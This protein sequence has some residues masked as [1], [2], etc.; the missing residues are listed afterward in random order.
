MRDTPKENKQNLWISLLNEVQ[1]NRRNAYG[2]VES[3][4]KPQLIILGSE[5]TGKTRLVGCISKDKDM[6][7]GIGLDYH[8]LNL[9]EDGRED[10]LN[11]G[12]WCL[13]GDP[14]LSNLLKFALNES[15][16]WHTMGIICVNYAEPWS[17]LNDLELWL[18]ILEQHINHLKITSE[19]IENL[20]SSI[21]Y[22]FKKFTDPSTVKNEV[23]KSSIGLLHQLSLQTPNVLKDQFEN[24]KWTFSPLHPKPIDRGDGIGAFSSSLP[25]HQHHQQQQQQQEQQK[26]QQTKD[27][28]PEKEEDEVDEDQSDHKSA[29]R[30]THEW[31]QSVITD[32]VMNKILPIPIIIVVTKTDMAD[33]LEKD[34]GYTD[35]KFDYILFN[36]R[37]LCLE[38]GAALIYTSA[39]EEI[40]TDILLN[41]IK[42]RLFDMPLINSA[43]LVD[44]K[45]IFIPAGWDSLHRI[46]LFKK[47]VSS[48]LIDNSY[49]QIVPKP[50]KLRRRPSCISKGVGAENM[51]TEEVNI[52][53][54]VED[55]QHFLN[56]MQS[57]LANMPTPTAT[58]GIGS[59]T[60]VGSITSS[61]SGESSLLNESMQSG[62]SNQSKPGSATDKEAVLSSFFNSL[63]ARK[64]LTESPIISKSIQQITS[65]KLNS[66]S[67]KDNE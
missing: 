4:D 36:L 43:M 55:D 26:P 5:S 33:L 22:S 21:V 62:H 51:P 19:E 45:A 41:Y 42:H 46:E 47:S 17:I 66:P 13:D 61:Q 16:I 14:Q 67:S 23:T 63:L 53:Q 52:L 44:P 29:E 64:S 40:N 11:M 25:Q 48:N 37:K 57:M 15:N 34:F 6:N 30:Q 59:G 32:G 31:L 38:Y 9:N 3:P 65:S 35:E 58:S 20:K 60:P 1:L 56:R 24:T 49:N 39:K 7:C 18:Q 8:F 10:T 28:Q 2:T 27:G 50:S 54:T 12:V